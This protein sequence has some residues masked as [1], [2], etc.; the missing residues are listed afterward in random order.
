MG[1]GHALKTIAHGVG[2]YKGSTSKILFLKKSGS[3]P[4]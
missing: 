1:V 4:D 3:D 2:S